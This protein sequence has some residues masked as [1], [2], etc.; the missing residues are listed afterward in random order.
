MNQEEARL[1]LEDCRVKIDDVDRRIVELL[2]ERT[3]VVEEIG[4]IKRHAN[5][6]VYEPKREDMVFANVRESNRG[7]LSQ[8][9]VRRISSGLS[10]RVDR[11]SGRGCR[12]R[13]RND[14]R[15]Q[16]ISGQG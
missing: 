5:L 10:M 7:P 12:T 1:K 2:N 6:P 14:P 16:A 13:M 4:R 11:F 3:T 8:E 9:A 15:M